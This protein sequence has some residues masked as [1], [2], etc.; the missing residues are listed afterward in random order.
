MA[1]TSV[2]RYAQAAFAIAVESDALKVW[3]RDL[4]AARGV[5]G[6]SD[7][8]AFLATPSVPINVKLDGVNTLLKDVEPLVRNLVSLLTSNGDIEHF[9][10]VCDTFRDLMDEHLGIGRAQITTAVPLDEARR[11]RIVTSLKEM[12]G[13]EQIEV[14][15]QVAPEVIGGVV[16]R[17]GD[18][19]FDGS[20]R[21]RLRSMQETL[22]QRPLSA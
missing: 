13:Y 17:V 2:R 5:V 3:A 8:V 11:E 9:E 19:L 22:T 18:R 14:T 12:T 7:V 10:G 21:S 6:E 20:T 4:D 15:E 1:S 16:V